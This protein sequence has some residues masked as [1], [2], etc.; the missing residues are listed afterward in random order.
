MDFLPNENNFRRLFLTSSSNEDESVDPVSSNCCC[1]CLAT[2]LGAFPLLG[3]TEETDPLLFST[4]WSANDA[5]GR[6]DEAGS[7]VTRAWELLPPAD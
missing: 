6:K 3:A 2:D 7:M 4:G 1:C 5:A